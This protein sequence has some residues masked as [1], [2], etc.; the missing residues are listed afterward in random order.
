[1]DPIKLTDEIFN[2]LVRCADA[3][4]SHF[5]VKGKKAREL[6]TEFICGAVRAIDI[7]NHGINAGPEATSC[8][9]THMYV[10]ILRDT[11]LTEI[12]PRPENG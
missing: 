11:E 6:K 12:K 8:V 1:M 4:N 3:R 7:I 9:P 2:A 5:G 10:N